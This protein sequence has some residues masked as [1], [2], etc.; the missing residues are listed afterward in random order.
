MSADMWEY[1]R[2]KYGTVNAV[3]EYYP[4]DSYAVKI[5]LQIVQLEKLIDLHFS[6]LT[7][8]TDSDN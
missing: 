7:S 2:D 8:E 4:N 5:A 6:E 1:W 3:L